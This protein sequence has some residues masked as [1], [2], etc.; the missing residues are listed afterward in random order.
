[1][2][3]RMFALCGVVGFGLAAC[4]DGS[5]SAGLRI[6]GNVA[7]AEGCAVDS[8]SMTFFDNGVIEAGSFNG[9]VFTPSARNDLQTVGDELLGPKTIYVTHASIQLRFYDPDFENITSDGSLLTF[10][11]PTAGAIE[12]NGGTA[13]FSF[14][15]VPPELLALIGERLGGPTLE[16]PRPRTTI[17]A[18][19][20]LFG[21][22]GG[23]GGEEESN[24][25][26][27]PVDVC[28]GCLS[29]DLGACA[30]LPAGFEP[31]L[32]GACNAV[33]DGVV[34]CCD[35]FMVCPARPPGA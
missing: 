23:G 17:D 18:Q 20:Q 1:M 6:I 7:P 9:Y 5:Q 16:N 28:N 2:N 31:S 8:T 33:Q 21:S 34:E 13:A 10:R 27:Y 22:R 11:A 29:S 12:P 24:V 26:R 15:I 35:N 4:V 30:D 32:G 3:V 14:E 19:V 25:Y